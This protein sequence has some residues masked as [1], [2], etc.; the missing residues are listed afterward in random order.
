MDH[1]VESLEVRPFHVTKISLDFWY[2][3]IG[4]SEVASRKQVS[5]ESH[6][7]VPGRKQN[8]R[9]NSADIAF[10]SRQK[11]THTTPALCWPDELL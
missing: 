4:R 6:H 5:V 2:C 8:W 10:V 7:P 11:Y 1:S 3:R 9:R